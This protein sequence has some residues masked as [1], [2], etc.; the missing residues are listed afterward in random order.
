MQSHPSQS[1]SKARRPARAAKSNDSATAFPSGKQSKVI[2][3]SM[4]RLSDFYALFDTFS[5]SILFYAST[6][7]VK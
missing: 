2:F 4:Q 6:F 3:V 5:P 7:F 1:A